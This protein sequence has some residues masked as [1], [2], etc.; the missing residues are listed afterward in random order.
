MSTQAIQE[1]LGAAVETATPEH[2]PYLTALW[3]RLAKAKPEGKAHEAAETAAEEKVEKD[4]GDEDEVCDECGAKVGPNDKKCKACGADLEDETPDTDDEE[5]AKAMA[6]LAKHGF[7]VLDVDGNVLAAP[8]PVDAVPDQ[9]TLAK[10]IGDAVAVA[11]QAALEPLQPLLKAMA[12][13]DA[14]PPAA[15]P[16]ATPPAGTELDPGTPATVEYLQKSFDVR[17]QAETE[18]MRKAFEDRLETA[19]AQKLDEIGKL[20]A[21]AVVAGYNLKKSHIPE[22]R[23]KLNQGM[24]THDQ[25]RATITAARKAGMNISPAEAHLV[26]LA[27]GN[28]DPAQV[29]PLLQMAGALVDAHGTAAPAT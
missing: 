22:E 3:E 17:L 29:A 21:G 6:T 19:V 4:Y 11:M 8:K 13:A 26:D 27:Y 9:E 15:E 2:K 10:S 23:D 5:M 28:N 18:E 7:D 14:A 12:D 24:P 20:P 16:E 1:A 25:A